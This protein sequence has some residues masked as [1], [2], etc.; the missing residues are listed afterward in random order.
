[1]ARML[2]DEKELEKVLD[3]DAVNLEFSRSFFKVKGSCRLEMGVDPRSHL[4]TV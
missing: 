1:M 2:V 4:W 3:L